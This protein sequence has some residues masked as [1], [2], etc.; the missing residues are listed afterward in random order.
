MDKQQFLAEAKALIKRS[1]N[2]AQTKKWII[3]IAEEIKKSGPLEIKP[4]TTCSVVESPNPTIIIGK[5]DLQLA[6]AVLSGHGTVGSS[7]D[8]DDKNKVNEWATIA[9]TTCLVNQGYNDFI[10]FLKDIIKIITAQ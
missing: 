3:E 6:P 8:P 4:Q 10:L 2:K 9:L 1:E 5:A 7:I